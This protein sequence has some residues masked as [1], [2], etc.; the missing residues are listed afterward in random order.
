MTQI[1]KSPIIAVRAVY[2]QENQSS[3]PTE[4]PESPTCKQLERLDTI[5]SEDNISAKENELEKDSR[6]SK[7]A[8]RL[9]SGG[10]NIRRMDSSDLEN[11]SSDLDS[12]SSDPEDLQNEETQHQ[13][14]GLLR[15]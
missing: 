7:R 15:Q 14:L 6:K 12:E 1:D 3:S 9:I 5:R 10:I 11:P 4:M 8:K 13:I 2:K